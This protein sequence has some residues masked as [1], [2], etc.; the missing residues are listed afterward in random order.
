MCPVGDTDSA[1]AL[2]ENTTSDYDLITSKCFHFVHEAAPTVS[3]CGG[4]L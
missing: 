3:V 1:L 4:V 2:D